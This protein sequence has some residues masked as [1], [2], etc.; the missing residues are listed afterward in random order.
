MVQVMMVQ[1]PIMMMM[2]IT[3][4]GLMSMMITRNRIT[5]KLSKQGSILTSTG[6]RPIISSL[7]TRRMLLMIYQRI[8][9]VI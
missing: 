6:K 1:L 3:I 8:F 5:K 4:S 7:E 9:I 2:I